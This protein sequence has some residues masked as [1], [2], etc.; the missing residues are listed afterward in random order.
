MAY[1]D[2]RLV[3]LYDG[4]NPDG[5]DHA[6]YRGL[7]ESI[8]AHRILDLGCGTGMLTV[9]LATPD[10]TV[11]GVDPSEA[12]LA[13]A[14]SRPGAERVHWV[15][16]DSRQIHGGEFDL[17]VMTGN[18]A[19]HIQDTDW[20]QTLTDLRAALRAGGTLAFESRNPARRAWESWA[21]QPVS[22]RDT[23]HGRLREWMEAAEHP[24]QRIAMRFHNLFV[25]T[26]EHV[27][28]DMTL[29][30]RGRDEIEVDLAAHGLVVDAVFGDWA[31]TPLHEGDPVMV[32]RAHAA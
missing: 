8:D 27:I 26:G 20:P 4:D 22:E 23:P 25:E 30:F 1:D 17:A 32:F 9:T 19:Q 21:D 7:A 14:R 10:R 12:M 6:F 28:E 5:D 31:G 11:V 18:V 24:R 15:R 13:V 16:G 2:P 3:D 29:I